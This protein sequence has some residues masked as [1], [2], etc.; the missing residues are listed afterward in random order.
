[1]PGVH[2]RAERAA[3]PHEVA[4]RSEYPLDGNGT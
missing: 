2:H 4:T 1:M 3:L